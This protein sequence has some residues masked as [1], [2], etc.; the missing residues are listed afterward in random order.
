[1]SKRPVVLVVMDGVGISDKDYGNAVNNAY[2]PTLHELKATSPNTAI[3]AHGLAVGLPSDGDMGNSEVGHNALGC[4]QIYSQGAKLVNESIESK[5][6]FK[7]DTWKALVDKCKENGKMHFIGLLSDGN[8]HSHINHLMA[9][10]E[11]AKEDGIK[12][13]RVHALLDG[14]DVPETSALIY[15]DQ[16]EEFFNKV[17]DDN[18]H[19][20]IASGG[21]R[22][23][24]TMDRYQ[25]N[26]P[27]VEAGWHTHVLGEGRQ[28]A[29]AKEAVETYRSESG[30]IDQDLPAFVIAK[31]G[32]P[33]GT[34]DDGDSV[35]LFNFRGDR[36][37]EI[38]LAFDNEVFTEF[39]RV[40]KPDVMYAGML[41]YDGD[42]K[43]P[44]NFLVYPPK[45]KHTL[46]EYLVKNNIRSYAIS[47]T[48]KYGH[49][50]YF[51]NGNNSQ[52]F[53]EEL[54]DW[55]EIKSDVVP[56]EQRPWMKCAEITDT[57]VE[58]IES[59]KYDFLRTNFPNGDMVGHTGN[60]EAT[61]I[62]VEAVDL[63]LDR[64]MKAVQKVNGILI[65]TAD[66]GNADEMYE[67]PKKEGD[68]PKAKT[69]HTLN[70]VPF[71]IYNKDVEIAEGDF[72]L[73]NVASTVAKL[74]EL[75]PDSHWLPAIIK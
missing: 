75:E 10:I 2:T 3:K 64:I 48:Q 52:K 63:C 58:A 67:K 31:D 38:S 32:K 74:L 25:A 40:R 4:G 72:G 12:E 69:S 7:T 70:K 71:I 19:A 24:I 11:Q 56:F 42:L 6:I 15:L 53:S 22:M 54:E 30:V 49:V 36:A 62:G 57:L 68:K 47:E 35:V 28:F 20:C 46:S 50:T 13:V 45:I 55:V 29:S 8:V 59:G 66:H 18:F 39:D 61:I 9:L 37:Q 43:I 41:Q 23:K 21:G 26:W 51:W 34:I 73:A 65:V 1:M 16:I 27:M 5:D 17:N 44:N 14:R 33:V 60:Y